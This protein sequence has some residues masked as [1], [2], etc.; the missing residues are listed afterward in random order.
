MPVPATAATDLPVVELFSSIQGEGPL[1]GCRQVFLRLAGCNL[2]CA[3]CDTDFH[4]AK[5]CQVESEP[6]GE[7]FVVWDNPVSLEALLAHLRQ[8]QQNWPHLHHSLSLTGGEPLLHAETLATWL[9]QISELLPVQLET[10]GTLPEALRRVVP[11][12]N[13]V[14]MDIKLASQTGEETP[15]QTHGEF[16]TAAAESCCSI[17]LVVGENTPQD[18]LSRAGELVARCAPQ[19][20]VF[21]QPKTVGGKCSVPGNLLLRWQALLAGYGLS[22]RVVPQTHCYL[23]VL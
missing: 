3:Y 20:E 14:V 4:V 18:E 23:A 5:H 12:I 22:V 13:W 19:A 1:V 16:M 15:W 11:W 9:P 10:N 17:K 21:L 2:N 8:W 7:E 6:G